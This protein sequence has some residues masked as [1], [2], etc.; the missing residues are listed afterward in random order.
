MRE[1]PE[2]DVTESGG[3]FPQFD[4]AVFAPGRYVQSVGRVGEAGHVVE[5]SL[6]IKVNT[7]DRRMDFFTYI[8]LIQISMITTS[9]ITN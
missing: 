1:W 5:V 8:Y 9:F 3:H 6:Q 4:F 7:K 2:G